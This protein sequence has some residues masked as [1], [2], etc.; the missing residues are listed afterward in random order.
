MIKRDFPLKVEMLYEKNA[1]T[2]WID[3]NFWGGPIIAKNIE[4]KTGMKFIE[5]ISNDI[6]YAKFQKLKKNNLYTFELRF[7][8]LYRS[9]RY[10]PFQKEI[11]FSGQKPLRIQGVGSGRSGTTSFAIWLD[12]MVFNDGEKIISKHETLAKRILS[13]IIEN[14]YDE[15]KNI[16]KSFSHNV[17]TAPYFSFAPQSIIGGK[18]IFL[19]RDGRNVV[20]SGMRRGWYLRESIWDKAKPDFTGSPFEKSCQFWS[21]SCEVLLPIADVVCRLEDLVNSEK[22]RYSL[23]KKLNIKSSDKPFPIANTSKTHFVEFEWTKKEEEIFRKYCG[24]FMDMFYSKWRS[25]ENI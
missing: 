25:N 24:K 2:I 13:L 20:N 9:I 21:K 11:L 18:V 6:P 4:K 23:L 17:E 7:K 8:N 12:N 16:V 3:S 15:V 1:I 5:R 22:V 19:I 14:K 10:K